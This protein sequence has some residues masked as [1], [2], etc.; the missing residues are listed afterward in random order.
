MDEL[1]GVPTQQLTRVLLGVFAASALIFVVLAARGRTS[2]TMAVRNVPRR[3]T[4]T[5]LIV[6]GLML[7]TLLFS[8]AFTT[9]NTLTN[10]LRAQALENIGRVDMVVRAEQPE[11]G[12]GASFGPSAGRPEV[13]EARERYF[14]GDL[15]GRIRDRLA[16]EES[17]AG[18]APL[19]K[20][21]VPV[22]SPQTNL[23]EPQVD[24]LGVDADSM[25]GFDRPKTASGGT[26]ALGDLEEN[27][28]YLSAKAA[29]G[30]GVSVGDKI[31]ASLIRPTTEPRTETP[32]EPK[33]QQRPGASQGR[34]GAP[35][36][37]SPPAGFEGEARPPDS[38]GEARA[39]QLEGQERSPAFVVAGV[40]ESGANPASDTSMVMPLKVLQ[41]S[42]GEEGRVNEVLISHRG[43]SAEGGRY[44]DTTVDKIRPILSA[45][46]LQA[47]PVKK[48]AVEE[49]DQQGELF[50]TLFVLFGQFSVAAGMLLIFLIFVMLAAERKKELGIARAVGMQ[51]SSLVRAFAFEDALYALL[52][53]AVGSALGV[54]VGW[55]MVQLIGRGLAGG[56]EDFR[57]AF[58]ASPEDVVLAFCMGM[59]LTFI[60]VLI[61]SWRV[62]RLNVVRA[63]RDIPEPDRKGHTVLGVIVALLTPLAGGVAFWHGLTTETIAFFLGGI[64]LV[65][66]GAALLARVFGLPDRAA[67]TASGL[68]LLALWLTPVTITAPAGMAKG[69]EMFFVSGIAIVVAGVW[70]VVFNADVLLWLVV[71]TFGRIRGLPPLLKTAVKYPTQ[72]LFR[73]GMTLAMFMLVV[74]T[75]TAMNFIQAA[76]SAAFGD[77]QRLSGGFEIR[78]D[79]GYADPIPDIKAAL[80]D[81][82][83]IQNGDVAAVGEV[84]NLP[85][86]VKQSSTNR[87]LKSLYVQGVDGGYSKSVDYDFETTTTG[88]GS[89]REV[90]KALQTAKDTAVISSDL[91][92]SRNVSTFGSSAEPRVELTG[93]Y[94]ED[95]YLPDDLYLHVK[96]PESGKTKNL[97][98]IG[99]LESSAYFAGD[100]VTS[101]RSLGSLAS[102]PVLAQTYYFDLG[103]GVSAATT[104][105]TLEKEFAQNGL[106]TQVT[107]QVIRDNDATRRIVFLLLRG[108]MGLGL[109]VGICALG[110]I[111]AR[112]VVERRQQIGMMRALGFQKG[113]VRLVFLIESSFIA[114]LGIG[115]GVALGLGFSGTLIDNISQN[116][117]GLEYTVPW[118]TLLLVVVV[119]YA[120]SL[121]TTFLPARRASKIY[122]AEAL[123]YE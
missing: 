37:G 82:E 109:V 25:Q 6:T 66:I 76:M 22:T 86:E 15:V 29:G 12:S 13:T 93:F 70:L 8:A 53:S 49:A 85:V 38:T 18:V 118:G 44:T 110:V 65:L 92:P 87:D 78:A 20:E 30:L 54:G 5:A 98:V 57:I 101:Q 69:P 39:V 10:S 106:Q 122:P 51:R 67:F 75:L 11:P 108:F 43:P 115:V 102:R 79:A 72:S 64:S 52:A 119:G 107:A 74:F 55:L 81:A 40:Y 56:S 77:A 59:V 62:S 33:S 16:D 32:S 89:A 114:L 111:A 48:D 116:I 23:S 19:A 123:R 99:V 3:K 103:G 88:Y 97:R 14:S 42:V 121:L 80:E 95:A 47:D 120:T 41:R 113:Q 46:G 1:F 26:L 84:S 2:F 90:W 117:P 58:A 71:A 94:G 83:G 104:A 4:Q 36:T 96:D 35:A 9:G 60:V 34:P 100:V 45:N 73:T 105:K 7:A 63:I 68:I 91:A 61:S 28:I 17:V 112:S 50:S 24:V 27:E 31:E 21:T